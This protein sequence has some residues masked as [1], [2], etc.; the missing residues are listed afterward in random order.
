[1]FEGSDVSSGSLRLPCVAALAAAALW[2][3]GCGGQA[4]RL[5]SGAGI[6]AVID[7]SQ[8]MVGPVSVRR[9][10]QSLRRKLSELRPGR[11]RREHI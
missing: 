3:G 4:P 1:M 7:G 5:V 2:V 8:H 9:Y 10:V 11:A 6:G